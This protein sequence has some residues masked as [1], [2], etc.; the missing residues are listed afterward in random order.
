MVKEYPSR[1]SDLEGV[2]SDEELR[3]LANLEFDADHSLLERWLELAEAALK[4]S[5]K[6]PERRD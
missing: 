3:E 1:N 6:Q 4:N 5:H 2:L